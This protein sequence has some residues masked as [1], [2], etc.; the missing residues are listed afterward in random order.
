MFFVFFLQ[1]QKVTK[2][3]LLLSVAMD[4]QGSELACSLYTLTVACMNKDTEYSE[5]VSSGSCIG[6]DANSHITFSLS[7]C[8]RAWWS[9][10]KVQHQMAG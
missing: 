4:M 8:L 9:H 7:L 3:W 10:V 2:L 1:S 6:F 5:S